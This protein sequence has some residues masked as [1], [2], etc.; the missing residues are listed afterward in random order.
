MKDFK[1]IIVLFC[2]LGIFTILTQANKSECHPEC[3]QST[4][5]SNDKTCTNQIKECDKQCL[6]M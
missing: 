4:G 1:S 5:C 3:I 2:L 6:E